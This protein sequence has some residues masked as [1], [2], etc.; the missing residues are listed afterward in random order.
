MT[1]TVGRDEVNANY[2]VVGSRGWL[3]SDTISVIE[4]CL[5]DARASLAYDDHREFEIDG[6]DASA[7]YVQKMHESRLEIARI[8]LIDFEVSFS[9][10]RVLGVATQDQIGDDPTWIAIHFA[11]PVPLDRALQIPFH[12]RVF[13][14][15]SVG[16]PLALKGIALKAHREGTAV[17]QEA[18]PDDFE[19]YKAAATGLQERDERH[20]EPIFKIWNKEERSTT[21]FAIRKWLGRRESW[22]IAYWLASQF[23]SGG[24]QVDRNNML[25]AMAWFEAIPD[26]VFDE[27]I[28]ESR[29]KQ[30]SRECRKLESFK[31]LGLKEARL[32]QVLNDLARIPLIDRIELAIK[33]INRLVDDEFLSQSFFDDC[34]RAKKIRDKAA[35]GGDDALETDLRSVVIS[36]A[37]IETLALLATIRALGV[38]IHKLRAI[39]NTYNPHPYARYFWAA[40]L[41]E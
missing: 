11:E 20:H 4:F 31:A 41:P 7:V 3:E 8:T 37:A 21:L 35:H 9:K 13:F 26:Y 34:K 17:S 40:R 16:H 39:T 15:L 18:F 2:L 29:I 25:R 38:D 28:P 6:N 10:R 32:S 14:E 23:T 30:F 24:N 12:I 5:P 1:K 19:L 22:S 27:I 33:D 36:T